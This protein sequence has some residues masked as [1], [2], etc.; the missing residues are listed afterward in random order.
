MNKTDIL[1]VFE[2]LRREIEQVLSCHF[3]VSCIIDYKNKYPRA[4]DYAMTDGF[5][6]YL[7]PKILKAE[8]PRVHGLLRHELGHAVLMQ[9][10]LHEHTERQVDQLAEAL[11]GDIIYYDEDDIQTIIPGITPRPKHLPN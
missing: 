4:R 1:L 10:G 2:S 6:V 8:L 5:I 7:S 11:F 9:A 3:Y